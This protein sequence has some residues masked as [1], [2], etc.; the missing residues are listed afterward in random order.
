ML[1]FHT[2]HT[3]LHWIV[4]LVMVGYLLQTGTFIRILQEENI[5]ISKQT[6]HWIML[7]SEG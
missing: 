2:K 6:E 4:P 7:W 1:Y 3:G 5:F